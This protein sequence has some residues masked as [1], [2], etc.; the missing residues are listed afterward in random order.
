MPFDPISAITAVLGLFKAI[1]G[2]K[3]LHDQYKN[4]PKEVKEILDECDN[5]ENKL[6]LAR[7]VMERIHE[8]VDQLENRDAAMSLFHRS[9]DEITITLEEIQAELPEVQ[10]R[11]RSK[12]GF[13]ENARFVWDS[14]YFKTQLSKVQ[15][16]DT[17]LQDTINMIS[18]LHTK[19]GHI[20]SHRPP[21]FANQACVTDFPQPWN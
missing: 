15:R 17:H 21:C 9:I 16:Y 13:W 11:R 7:E 14:D 19:Y 10:A 2:L 8:T 12:L 5:I 20:Y 6:K 3:D 1:T 18:G 4:A